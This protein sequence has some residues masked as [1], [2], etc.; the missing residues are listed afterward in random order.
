[1][2]IHLCLVSSDQGANTLVR[3]AQLSLIPRT[4][5]KH[6]IMEAIGVEFSISVYDPLTSGRPLAQYLLDI[7]RSDAIALLVDKSLG[8]ITND[9]ACACFIAEVEFPAYPKLNYRNYFTSILSR[10]LWRLTDFITIMNDGANEQVML[11]PFR[12]FNAKQLRDLREICRSD[13]LSPEFINNVM[14]HVESLKNR[15]RPHRKSNYPHLYI[16]DDDEKIFKYGLE[17]HAVLATGE[18][19]TVDCILTGNFR[20]GKRI[21]TDRHYNV[22]K[23]VGKDT[24]IGGLFTDCHDAVHNVTPTTHLNIFSNDYRA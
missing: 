20:F 5:R 9:I 6:E 17:R 11:L 2:H 1:M 24:W 14:H 19:H 8:G 10:L 4:F 22:S 18:P 21:P 16:V 15:R 23:E 7:P 3:K 13:T 12:N